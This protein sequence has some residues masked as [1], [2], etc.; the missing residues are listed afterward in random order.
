[1]TTTSVKPYAIRPRYNGF[2]LIELLFVIAIISVLATL[3]VGVLGS[4]SNDAR[5]A[6]TRA[7]V[8][9]IEQ[10]FQAQLEEYEVRRLPFRRAIVNLTN[11]I[12]SRGAW[13]GTST[14]G[15][16]L[17]LV[18]FKNLNRMLTVDLVRSEIPNGRSDTPGLGQFPSPAMLDYLQ[19]VLGV[20][21]ITEDPSTTD[22]PFRGIPSYQFSGGI[23]R[24]AG[25]N[26]SGLNTPADMRSRE[27]RF[28]D[29]A[30]I[31]HRFLL[32]IDFNGSTALDALGSSA[33][34]DSDGDGQLEVVD[35]WGEPIFFQFLQPNIDVEMTNPTFGVWAPVAGAASTTETEIDQRDSVADFTMANRASIKP[36]RVDQ[37]TPLV[38]SSKLLEIDGTPVDFTQLSP[39]PMP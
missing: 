5:T 11:D 29:A 17:F 16:G 10:I 1:M 3:A 30:E 26:F 38:S 23:A 39:L 2:T 12:I 9:I 24:W 32:Q 7:R 22:P 8:R 21:G 4:A 28:A 34:G 18:H 15:E 36:V 35:A 27:Q 14:T 20:T 33:V 6:S 25:A 37:L 31:L 19:N 13:S